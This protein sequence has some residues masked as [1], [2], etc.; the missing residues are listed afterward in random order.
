MYS[1]ALLQPPHAIVFPLLTIWDI[2]RRLCH[3]PIQFN[4][5]LGLSSPIIVISHGCNK[6]VLIVV[7]I[8][9]SCGFGN[10]SFCFLFRQF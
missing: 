3:W 6:I 2:R 7:I 10:L 9:Y 4:I 8:Y 1:N 5:L